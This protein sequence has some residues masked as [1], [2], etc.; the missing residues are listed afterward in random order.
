MIMEGVAKRNFLKNYYKGTH[1]V[2]SL[3]RLQ[4]LHSGKRVAGRTG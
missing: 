2:S 3:I 4:Y 1:F